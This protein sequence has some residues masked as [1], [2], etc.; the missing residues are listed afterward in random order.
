[1]ATSIHHQVT[2]LRGFL[3][4]LE[5]W[6]QIARGEPIDISKIPDDWSRNPSRFFSGLISESTVPPPPIPFEL[7]ETPA[8]GVPE[9]LMQPSK[10]T[11][12]K[13][14]SNS[15]EQLKNDFSPSASGDGWI[16]SG[17]ALA[18]LLCGA[19]TRARHNANVPRLVGRSTLESDTEKVAMAADGRERAPRGDMAGKYYGNFNNLPGVI[20]SRSDLLSLTNESAA[21]IAVAI[22][23]G[24]NDQLSP[25]SIAKRIAFFEAPETNTPPGRILFTADV[26]LTN[27]CRFDLQSPKLGFGWGKPFLATSGGGTVYPPAYSIMTQNKVSGETF[28]MLTVEEAGE[29]ALKADELMNKYATLIPNQPSV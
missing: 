7:L 10:I 5:A 25:E 13:I 8:T 3:E 17:D 29:E 14:S 6:A 19:V 16:S 9:Y 18:T 21:R 12:W 11:N 24:L 28:V 20:M 27:W 23:K 4:F 22:R 2:D 15:L 26:I 1:V